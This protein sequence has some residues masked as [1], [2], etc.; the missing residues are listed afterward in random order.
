[1]AKTEKENKDSVKTSWIT[2]NVSSPII[3]F[4][5]LPIVFLTFISL[6]SFKEGVLCYTLLSLIVLLILVFV[7]LLF[8]KPQTL[9]IDGKGHIEMFKEELA[10]GGD[11]PN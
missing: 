9:T 10:S 4:I 1:M 5:A 3:A 2:V 11:S 7:F 8:W 6:N